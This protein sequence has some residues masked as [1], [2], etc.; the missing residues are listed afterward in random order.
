M[1][2]LG[3]RDEVCE[4]SGAEF[5]HSVRLSIDDPYVLDLLAYAG[6][7]GGMLNHTM[8]VSFADPI[9]YAELD[10]FL[11][12]MEQVMQTAGAIESFA[13]R[14]HIAVPAD[15]HSP[16]FVATA[17]VQLGLTDLDALNASFAVPGVDELIERWQ[18]RRPYRVVWVNHEPLT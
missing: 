5:I 18:A 9:P 8:V 7:N 10:Q 15:E 13:A 1:Q 4:V 6:W 11:R 12:E 17:V 2:F 14:R 3:D 16:V